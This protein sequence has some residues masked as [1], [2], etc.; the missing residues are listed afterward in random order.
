MPMYFKVAV[1][2]GKHISFL[3]FKMLYGVILQVF[4][5]FTAGPLTFFFGFAEL[6]E[7]IHP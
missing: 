3:V 5:S 7:L 4:H 1:A 6:K 2:G